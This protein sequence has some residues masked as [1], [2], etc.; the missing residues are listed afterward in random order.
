MLPER[1][2]GGFTAETL[3]TQR[4]RKDFEQVHRERRE[5]R[6]EQRREDAEGNEES[7]VY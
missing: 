5:R 6:F 4:G 2:T 3:R 1:K 7:R